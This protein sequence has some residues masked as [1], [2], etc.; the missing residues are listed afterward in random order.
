MKSQIRTPLKLQKSGTQIAQTRPPLSTHSAGITTMRLTAR[1]ADELRAGQGQ[2]AA[3]AVR[4]EQSTGLHTPRRRGGGTGGHK[5]VSGSV[6]EV[7]AHT[8]SEFPPRSSIRGP[9]EIIIVDITASVR[10]SPRH[11]RARTVETSRSEN[12]S[13]SA[14]VAAGCSV[15]QVVSAVVFAADESAA[16]VQQSPLADASSETKNATSIAGKLSSWEGSLSGCCSC[17]AASTT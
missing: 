14:G 10:V 12:S 1:S 7:R 2:L 3:S 9:S 11:C 8:P 17:F 13:G 16:F 15:Q 5:V 6:S 4:A